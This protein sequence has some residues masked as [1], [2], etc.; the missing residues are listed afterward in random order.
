MSLS[1][2]VV[3]VVVVGYGR[4]VH[5]HNHRDW[6]MRL[7]TVRMFGKIDPDLKNSRVDTP[8][9]CENTHAQS[10]V[11]KIVF[12]CELFTLKKRIGCVK[13]FICVVEQVGGD[14]GNKFS[15]GL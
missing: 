3:Y 11:R 6:L 14:F 9:L 13:T 7:F 12:S 8:V 4:D 1:A 10:A 5:S 15:L 2:I